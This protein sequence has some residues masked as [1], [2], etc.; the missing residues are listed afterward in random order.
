MYLRK[1]Y[2]LDT[3]ILIQ[4]GGSGIKGFD[5]NFVVITHITLEELDGLKRG[6]TTGYDARQALKMI[7]EIIKDGD[8]NKGIKMDNGG[9]FILEPDGVLQENLPIGWK[10]DKPDNCIISATISIKKKHSRSKVILV[11]N[12]RG[13]RIKA[14]AAGLDVEEY[15]NGQIRTE[16]LYTGR[17]VVPASAEYVNRLYKNG[18][19]EITDEDYSRFG[20]EYPFVE[21]QY[22]RVEDFETNMSRHAA[23]CVF[24]NGKLYTLDEVAKVGIKGRNEGQKYAINALLDSEIPL[25]A[26]IGPAGCGKTYISLAIALYLMREK[27]EYDNIYISRSNTI[28]E[29]EDLGFLPGD[30]TQKMDPLLYPF[31]D[32]LE[33][34]MGMD[35][36]DEL[37]ELE[38]SGQISICPMA[39]IRGRSIDHAFIIVDEAQNISQNQMKTLV[40]RLGE[41]SKLVICGDPAQIDNNRLDARSNGLVYCADRMKGQ[42]RFSQVT[43]TEDE[44][45]RSEIAKLAAKLL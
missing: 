4:T 15:K 36:Q 26:L 22:V 40:S 13:M 16:K 25:V 34:L 43:F 1:Y 2:V 24:R 19:V 5:D 6:M 37:R 11:T 31:H 44:C 20:L 29:Q 33:K 23:E 41:G 28:P 45:V 42:T 21:N 32:N 17:V 35:G 27:G 9:T 3:N 10:L 18:A 39:Y 8:P 14:R 30:L 38:D 12:D 7:D